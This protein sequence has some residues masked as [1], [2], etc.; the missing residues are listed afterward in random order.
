MSD[1][2]RGLSSV[3]RCFLGLI[4]ADRLTAGSMVSCP[5][6]VVSWTSS[7][8]TAQIVAA[9]SM[10]KCP[11]RLEPLQIATL[12][13]IPNLDATLWNTQTEVCGYTSKSKGCSHKLQIAFFHNRSNGFGITQQPKNAEAPF[14]SP[15]GA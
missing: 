14:F 4:D 10:A 15:I 8:E 5:W 11:P 9:R 7:T 13:R 1:V 12:Q 3:V 2:V 6:S